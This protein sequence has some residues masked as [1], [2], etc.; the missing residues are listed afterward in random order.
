VRSV[1][2]VTFGA[3]CL[4]LALA[5]FFEDQ[6]RLVARHAMVRLRGVGFFTRAAV[7]E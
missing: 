7:Q 3:Q 2:S 4:L 5:G 1:V 6:I